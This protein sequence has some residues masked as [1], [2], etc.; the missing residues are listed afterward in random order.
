MQGLCSEASG[1]EKTSGRF[2][3]LL[4][5]SSSPSNARKQSRTL[6]T[7]KDATKLSEKSVLK[8]TADLFNILTPL[9]LWSSWCQPDTGDCPL[10]LNV[11]TR[12]RAFLSLLNFDFTERGRSEMFHLPLHQHWCSD[13]AIV[14]AIMTKVFF[15]LLVSRLGRFKSPTSDKWMNKEFARFH[16]AHL[17]H[18]NLPWESTTTPSICIAKGSRHGSCCCSSIPVR[19]K[20]KRVILTGCLTYQMSPPTGIDGS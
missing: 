10:Y 7:V 20:I 14:Q 16:S 6:D 13:P 4:Q 18:T 8:N 9:V 19:A 3:S 17:H 2:I 5:G 1:C 15:E 11:S 12:Y